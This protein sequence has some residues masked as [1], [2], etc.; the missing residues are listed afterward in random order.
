MSATL[1]NILPFKRDRYFDLAKAQGLQN[2][3]QQLHH[4]LWELEQECFDTPNG[5]QPEMWKTL[6]EMR[7]FSRELW[8]LKLSQQQH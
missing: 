7:I 5:Y 2:A 4:D 3:V 1:S 6:N 8:D